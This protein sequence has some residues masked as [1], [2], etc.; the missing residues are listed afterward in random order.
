[1]TV[2]QVPYSHGGSSTKRSVTKASYRSIPKIVAVAG[3]KGGVGKTTIAVVLATEAMAQGLKVLLVDA[4]TQRSTRQWG[5]AA[6][7]AGNPAPTVIEMSA[8][9][10]QPGQ[11]PALSGQYDLT[12]IDC[13][14]RH[15][16]TQG[17]ALML[18]DVVILPCGPSSVDG[19]ALAGSVELVNRARTLRPELQAVV[20]INRVKPR[21]ALANSARDDLAA[22]GLPVLRS[23]L[24]DR[25]A[26]QES[27]GFGRSVAQHAPK[28][29]A[30][31]E[32]RALFAEVMEMAHK[33]SSS[34]GLSA[35]GEKAHG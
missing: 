18:A 7:S 15:D 21:T 24:H 1:M 10:A 22:T 27:L 2:S 25:V 32:V 26:Y 13:P 3:Q 23:Q 16:A 34:A 19:W 11:L 12:I 8:T 4:D 5:D 31:A 29:P 28:D 6:I 9:M 30:A 33:G 35:R 17:A 20:A 14:G